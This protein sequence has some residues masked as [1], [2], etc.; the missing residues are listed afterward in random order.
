MVRAHVRRAPRVP[1]LWR[2]CEQR[3]RVCQDLAALCRCAN[4]SPWI[5]IRRISF[6]EEGFVDDT[7]AF[8]EERGQPCVCVRTTVPSAM[9]PWTLPTQS[10]GVQRGAWFYALVMHCCVTQ[11]RGPFFCW[12]VTMN[13]WFKF[14]SV[15][16]WPRRTPDDVQRA[17][18]YA[19]PC[20]RYCFGRCELL[21]S[22]R[23]AS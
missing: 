3:L 22:S 15:V 9:R 20:G 2:S 12:L 19:C 17:S 4:N 5:A 7:F 1:W 14:L 23:L 6:V 21:H 18:P 13:S 16:I 10:A 11:K 8:A